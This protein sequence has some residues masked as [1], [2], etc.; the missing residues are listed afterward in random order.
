MEPGKDRAVGERG[1]DGSYIDRVSQAQTNRGRLLPTLSAFEAVSIAGLVDSGELRD[2]G[3][4]EFLPPTEG[5][6]L[7]IEFCG[8]FLRCQTC[9][10]FA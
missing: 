9:L 4:D 1:R 5:L 10:G 6:S 7:C 8:D 3:I 2:F